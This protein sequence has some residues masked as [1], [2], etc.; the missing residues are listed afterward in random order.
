MMGPMHE[1][2]AAPAGLPLVGRDRD[3]DRARAALAEASGGQGQIVFVVGHMG[4]GKTRLAEEAVSVAGQEGFLVLVGRTPAAGS[5]LAYAP[6]LAAFGSVLRSW[7]RP[8]RDRLVADLPRL[9]RLWPELGLPPPP[10]AQE[11]ELERALLFEAVARLLERLADRGPVALFVDDLH[12]ADA[13]SLALLGYLIPAVATLP[14]LLIGTYRPEG[15][16]SNK[17]VRQFVTDAR[18]AGVVTELPL[19]GLDADDVQ[20]LAAGLLGG[21]PP[22]SL[23]E[24]AARAGGTPLFVEALVR[25]LIE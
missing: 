11:P 14:I 16:S 17:G 8:E 23:L 19:Q 7:H 10:P 18:R 20:A 21:E 12:W 6:L 22:A 1:T 3:L 13:P 2:V 24:L 4:M 9:G 15:L 5:G 25:G